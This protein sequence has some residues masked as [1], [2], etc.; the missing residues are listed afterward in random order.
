[1][2][3]EDNPITARDLL[4][5]LE[6]CGY[7]AQ[8]AYNA[9]Q[10]KVG[11]GDF[12][13]DLLLVDIQLKKGFSGIDLIKSLDGSLDI[14]FIYLTA[15]SKGAIVSE[16]METQPSAFLKKPFDQRDVVKAIK[17]ALNQ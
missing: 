8:I 15:N 1:M 13:P 17:A 12:D 11:I 4:E 7:V 14:P 16:A 2:I 6:E 9:D 3:V 10:A 5:I